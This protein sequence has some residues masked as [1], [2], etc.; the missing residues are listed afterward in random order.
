VSESMTSVY[1][2][3]GKLLLA[4]K[5]LFLDLCASTR[6]LFASQSVYWVQTR[7][8][9]FMVQIRIVNESEQL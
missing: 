3:S 5:S 9:G 6:L 7:D 8:V 1:T 4:H 2:L